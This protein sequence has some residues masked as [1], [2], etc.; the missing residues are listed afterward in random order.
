MIGIV[1]STVTSTIPRISD[2]YTMKAAYLLS[3]KVLALGV[4]GCLLEMK[5]VINSYTLKQ[6]TEKL[7]K[8]LFDANNEIGYNYVLN[9]KHSMKQFSQL[10]HP[11]KGQI[12]A[13]VNLERDLSKYYDD[14]F[15]DNYSFYKSIGFGDLEKLLEKDILDS[16]LLEMSV[17]PVPEDN[18]PNLNL[19]AHLKKLLYPSGNPDDTL[20]NFVTMDFL[21]DYHQLVPEVKCVEDITPEQQELIDSKVKLWNCLEIANLD[22][23]SAVDLKG[24]RMQLMKHGTAFKQKVNDFIRMNSEDVMTTEELDKYFDDVFSIESE[25]LQAIIDTSDIIYHKKLTGLF[26]PFR[27]ELTIGEASLDYWFTYLEKFSIVDLPTLNFVRE[28]I[29]LHKDYPRFVPFICVSNLYKNM[30]E[31]AMLMAKEMEESE[32]PKLRKFIAAED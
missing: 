11:A 26:N 28:D 8:I 15:G 3:D 18:S 12:V 17:K 6:K 31:M 23:L 2:S 32:L 14:V 4:S 16:H 22:R 30:D 25:K 9:V 1:F 21:E 13:N 19:A 7:E 5:E 10:K 20:I 27:F 29:K 24:L